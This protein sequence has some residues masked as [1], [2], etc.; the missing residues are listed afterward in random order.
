MTDPLSPDL[1]STSLTAILSRLGC[2]KLRVIELFNFDDA[3][4]AES[5]HS[6]ILF[7][8]WTPNP[9]DP[10][11][12]PQNS[13]NGDES[14][15]G[16]EM[17][18]AN[19]I[20][21]NAGAVQALVMALMN[22]GKTVQIGERL[23]QL[24]EFTR[25][26]P[27]E[28]KSVVVKGTDGIKEVVKELHDKL[29]E[30]EDE[31]WYYTIW[32]LSPKRPVLYRMDGIDQGPECI[33]E[34]D[35]GKTALYYARDDLL[36]KI[37]ELREYDIE[38]RVFAIADEDE[39]QRDRE[40][41]GESLKTTDVVNGNS[42][43]SVEAKALNNGGGDGH[44]KNASSSLLGSNSLKPEHTRFEYETFFTEM[45]KVLGSKGAL[46]RMV[47]KSLGEVEDD[48]GFRIKKPKTIAPKEPMQQDGE[49]ANKE[50]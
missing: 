30:G 23:N 8:R 10:E 28:L 7:Y 43:P 5:Y 14:H 24:K 11:W 6:L 34:T 26:M 47:D 45:L 21:D 3:E 39:R 16:R 49:V 15:T 29:E 44:S 50:T 36:R 27:A 9:P 32:S 1:N 40:S 4:D 20:I 19:Q 41:K 13:Q 18:F 38:F 48:E 17:W 2:K 42:S 46:L 37:K 22:L 33:G 12:N 31:V 25:D 35:E